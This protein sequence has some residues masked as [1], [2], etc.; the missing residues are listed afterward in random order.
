LERIEKLKAEGKWKTAAE[1]K[2]EEEM[3][4]ARAK[5][6]ANAVNLDEL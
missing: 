2:K 4:I 6:G 3:A 1:R 5:L